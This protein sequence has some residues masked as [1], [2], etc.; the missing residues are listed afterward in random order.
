MDN[1]REWREDLDEVVLAAYEAAEDVMN[2]W[3][4][5]L[6]TDEMNEVMRRLVE[7]IQEDLE[8]GA[9]G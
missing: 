7:T 4:R 2:D 3:R 6:S 9:I 1:A 5:T 8:E